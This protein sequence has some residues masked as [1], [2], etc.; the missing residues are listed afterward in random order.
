MHR[1]R[2]VYGVSPNCHLFDTESFCKVSKTGAALVSGSIID[3]WLLTGR[4]ICPGWALAA[5]QAISPA[6]RP[7]VAMVGEDV[8]EKHVDKGK[9]SLF[10]FF[11]FL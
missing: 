6:S 2:Y 4:D 11:C 1:I 5:W 9:T 8:A 7:R 3:A 10:V